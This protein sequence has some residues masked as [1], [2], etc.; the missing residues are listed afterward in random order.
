M[1][2]GIEA[3]QSRYASFVEERDWEQYHTPQ[4]IATALSVEANELLECFLWHDNVSAD[5]ISADQELMNYIEEELADVVIYAL[6]M[7]EQLDMNLLD[8]VEAKLK[9]NEERFDEERVADIE[10]NLERWQRD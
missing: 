7:A 10:A 4:N 9:A 3:L 5:E 1:S 2:D 8:V 6:G